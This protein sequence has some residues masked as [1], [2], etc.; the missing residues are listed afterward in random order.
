MV[1]I[2]I[3]HNLFYPAVLIACDFLRN[4]DLDLLEIFYNFKVSFLF[5]TI[6]FFSELIFGLIIYM[7]QSQFFK[8][9]KQKK[10]ENYKGI[11]LITTDDNSK[12]PIQ[13]SVLKINLIIFLITF[14]DYF[15]FSIQIY[16]NLK[17]EDII[18]ETLT[19]RLTSIMT[20]F[21]ALFCVLL[22]KTNIYRHQKCSLIVIGSC[23]I[24]ILIYE[25][26]I[27]KKTL[28][29]IKELGLIFAIHFCHSVIACL[30]KYLIECNFINPFYMLMFEGI[31]GLILLFITFI[32]HLVFFHKNL[33]EGI[34]GQNNYLLIIIFLI[35][36]FLLSGGRNSYKE[37]T[38]KIFSPMTISLS[39]CIL[40]PLLIIYYLLIDE[41]K[42][43][44]NYNYFKL[45]HL[46]VN[47]IISFI[48]V[49][50]G[51]IY[52]EVLILYFCSLE[53]DTY[54]EITKRGIRDSFL[55]YGINDDTDDLD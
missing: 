48:I 41:D 5:T 32:I 55:D 36:F 50:A 24:I 8:K 43:I 38:N 1:K 10:Y 53:R 27:E 54:I 34:T 45:S 21:S 26:M 22:F 4:I 35:I 2:G 6:M 51:C 33:F 13:I 17:G 44:F 39:Y 9:R 37:I 11:E 28:D 42:K 14:F 3:R 16:F 52:N 18:S 46:V 23:L 20:I 15:Q 40:N 12:M 49:F 29:F 19:I 7:Y 25:F 30:E 47:I 31:Y